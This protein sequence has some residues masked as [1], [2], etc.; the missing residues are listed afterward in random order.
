MP[1]PNLREIAPNLELGSEGWWGARA[2]SDVSYPDDGNAFCF[3]VED[4]SFWF[5][6]RNRCILEAIKLFPPTGAIFDVGGGNGYVARS[7]QDLGLEVVLVEPGLV[8][9]RNEL[10]REVRQVV[11]PTRVGWL[12]VSH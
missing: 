5:R 11:R 1:I 6:H 10:K 8:G 9:V 2:V 3:A 12:G 4:S 7:I